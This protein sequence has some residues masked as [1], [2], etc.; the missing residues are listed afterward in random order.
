MCCKP[1]I[2]VVDDNQANITPIQMM[3]LEFFKL[4]IEEAPNGKIA[5]EMFREGFNRECGCSNRA[6]KTIFMDV[7]MPVM[8]GIEA[9]KFIMADL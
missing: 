3:I 9:T 6:Y 8:D 4:E 2:L 5:V 7:Q 1:R